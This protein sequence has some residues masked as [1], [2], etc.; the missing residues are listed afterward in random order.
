MIAAGYV[1]TAATAWSYWRWFSP[2]PELILSNIQAAAITGAIGGATAYA[3]L[4]LWKWLAAM[5]AAPAKLY[6]MQEA[7]I[8]ALSAE[9]EKL[10]ASE[11]VLD[12]RIA[13]LEEVLGPASRKFAWPFTLE[14]RFGAD[15]GN[16]AGGQRV[17]VRLLSVALE[18][19]APIEPGVIELEFDQPVYSAFG[20][21]RGSDKEP[22]AKDH[23]PVVV[24]EDRYQNRFRLGF[25]DG[26]LVAGSEIL[27]KVYFQAP[28]RLVRVSI[29]DAKP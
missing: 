8:S 17:A 7:R 24:A 29:P 27:I 3:L 10:S 28:A 12:P 18:A 20:F 6:G 5:L 22:A 16:P 23:P 14:L 19:T 11:P 25:P 26:S 1:S 21:L 9:R 15:S 4:L 13:C 2:E